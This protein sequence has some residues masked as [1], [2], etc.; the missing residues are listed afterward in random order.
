MTVVS[1]NIHNTVVLNPAN[2]TV[3][4]TNATGQPVPPLPAAPSAAGLSRPSNANSSILLQTH[5][6]AAAAAAVALPA[7][8][9]L[10]SGQAHPA[11]LP[12]S[13]LPPGR[14]ANPQQLRPGT[15]P[16][17]GS[18]ARQQRPGVPPAAA[19]TTSHGLPVPIAPPLV[20][21]QAVRTCSVRFSA[22]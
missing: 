18:A 13:H 15:Q 4:V 21:G 17:P 14:F 7:A 12:G 20:L 1:V 22:A 9:A 10:R 2:H 8:A 16:V 19:L 11:A 6:T 5:P 3:V